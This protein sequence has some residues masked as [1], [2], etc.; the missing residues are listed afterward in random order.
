[1]Q[2]FNFT[3]NSTYIPSTQDKMIFIHLLLTLLNFVFCIKKNKLMYILLGINGAMLYSLAIDNAIERHAKFTLLLFYSLFYLIHVF[4]IHFRI[5]TV[6]ITKPYDMTND[7]NDEEYVY[8][9]DHDD[10]SYE[11]KMSE[12]NFSD[13]ETESSSSEDEN[14]KDNNENNKKE[15]VI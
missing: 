10:D 14:E 2:A 1:M 5:K 9:S 13:T 6:Y 11:E 7:P 8:K 15:K 12:E 4:Q 3:Q